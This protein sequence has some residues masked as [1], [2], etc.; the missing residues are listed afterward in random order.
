MSV[1]AGGRE[2]LQVRGFAMGLF[3]LGL[4]VSADHDFQETMIF[5]PLDCG[6]QEGGRICC[7]AS[8]QCNDAFERDPQTPEKRDGDGGPGKQGLEAGP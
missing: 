4:S 6:R 8:E 7:R 5:P 2:G 1:Y 3:H